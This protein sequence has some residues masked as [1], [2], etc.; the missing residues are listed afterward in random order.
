M[1]ILTIDADLGDGAAR[2]ASGTRSSPTRSP[3]CLPIARWP[4][5]AIGSSGSA[6]GRGC[7]TTPARRRW[8]PSR[9]CSVM[10]SRP[11]EAVYTSKRY[12]LSGQ[13]LAP[14]RMSSRSPGSCSPTTSSSSGGSGRAGMGS[15][16]GHRHHHPQGAAGPRPTV[17]VIPI[18][19]DATLQRISDER[20]LALN[21]N[22]IPVIRAYFSDPRVRAE[23]A[24]VGLSDPTDVELEYISQARSDH[25]NHNTFRGLFHYRDLDERAER[26]RST[27]CSR[28]ASR[29][30]P[31]SWR[32]RNPGWCRCSGTT[33]ASGAWTTN[34]I[35]SSPARPT[36]RPPTWKPT[37][38][39]SP[40]SSAS[41][42]TPWA[43]ARAPSSSWAAT[44]SAWGRGT[45]PGR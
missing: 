25:C 38:G 37:A 7:G 5:T 39:P 20:N 30:R 22:D 8:R 11:A 35:M 28:P 10:R 45:T 6:S 36:T 33:P 1:N 31:W 4:S 26:R 27:T 2:S 3:R 13:R 21:P 43:P 34:T 15:G 23:R 40:A 18:D 14:T 9:I 29:R 12:C 17:T 44:A 24:A 16:R 32:R 42:A 41:T 19:S